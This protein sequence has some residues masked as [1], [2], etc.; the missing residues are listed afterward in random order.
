M[1]HPEHTAMIDEA[2]CLKVRRILKGL[3]EDTFD[4][5]DTMRIPNNG[6][7]L[8]K[9]GKFVRYTTS[10]GRIDDSHE[11]HA[12]AF[13]RSIL[14]LPYFASVRSHMVAQK[15][16]ARGKCRDCHTPTPPPTPPTPPTP[17]PPPSIDFK[18]DFSS[19]RRKP[20]KIYPQGKVGTYKGHKNVVGTVH[21][22][23]TIRASAPIVVD[24]STRTRL[25]TRHRRNEAHVRHNHAVLDTHQSRSFLVDDHAHSCPRSS[26]SQSATCRKYSSSSARR[27]ETYQH[28]I[29]TYPQTCTPGKTTGSRERARKRRKDTL[30]VAPVLQPVTSGK[31][32]RCLKR[33]RCMDEHECRLKLAKFF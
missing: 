7:P 14:T 32:I 26:A 28:P 11:A 30:R 18:I 3:D 1:G 16:G 17:T 27:T 5:L 29:P 22:K 10:N 25:Q 33:K 9:N 20:K 15:S 24:R 21:L 13:Q 12:H 2:A 6:E 31:L 19:L 8:Y 4:V 23:H